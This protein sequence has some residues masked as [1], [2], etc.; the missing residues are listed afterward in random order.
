[1]KTIRMSAVWALPLGIAAV[2]AA[3]CQGSNPLAEKT[4]AGAGGGAASG[5]ATGDA[6]TGGQATGGAEQPPGGG[7]VGTGGQGLGGAGGQGSGGQGTGGAPTGDAGV[8]AGDALVGPPGDRDDDG[9]PDA[10]DNCPSGANHNQEDADGDG[11]GDVCDVCPNVR[12]PSQ[13][14]ADMDGVGDACD[15]PVGPDGDR[16]DDGVPDARDNC[17]DAANNGQENADG[18]AAGDACDACPRDPAVVA[19]QCGPDAMANPNP[20]DFGSVPVNCGSVT[21]EVTVTGEPEACLTGVE[22]VGPCE[23][24]EVQGPRGE[25]CAAL[26]DTPVVRVTYGPGAEG[27]LACTLVL[28]VTRGR[29]TRI[30][31]PLLGTGGGRRVVERFIATPPEQVDVVF[32]MDNSGSMQ[33]IQDSLDTRF[34]DFFQRANAEGTDWRMGVATTDM[35]D[36]RHRG[37]FQGPGVFTPGP[38]AE[39]DWSEAVNR[40]TDGSGTEQ[41]LAASVAA[42]DREVNRN[43][44]R[45]AADLAVVVVSD[46]DDQSQAAAATYAAQWRAA[47]GDWPARVSAHG[48]HGVNAQGAPSD[49][50]NDGL[51][52]SA[53]Q[54]YVTAYSDVGGRAWTI[55]GDH[56]QALRAMSDRI[57]GPRRAFELTQAADGQPVVRVNGAV[58][59]RWVWSAQ[60]RVVRLPGNVDSLADGD[61]IEV[62]YDAN[63]R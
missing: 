38:Q 33:P 24:I 58:D 5:G 13:A 36:E 29:E 10:D 21:R 48:L 31:V 27:E 45:D 62:E 32:I 19:G 43:F 37:R 9:I 63:C 55:C 25:G 17:P 44:H 53:G 50:E 16:D 60:T 35:E 42:L 47:A 49:C 51:S 41:G 30:E 7:N 59:A 18:D 40:G 2:L 34:G 23:G 28:R 39:G 12:D 54:R 52:A 46:E 57:F 61:V 11:F 56:R 8:P 3:G 22:L 6:G 4:D 1:M 26:R 15:L 20:V 14:D